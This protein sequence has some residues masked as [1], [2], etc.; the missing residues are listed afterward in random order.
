MPKK[1]RMLRPG[2]KSMGREP[3]NSVEN[4]TEDQIRTKHAVRTADIKRRA[5]AK[6]NEIVYK[7]RHGMSKQENPNEYH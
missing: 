5:R 1:L 2:Q 4:K 3:V 7:A 6:S